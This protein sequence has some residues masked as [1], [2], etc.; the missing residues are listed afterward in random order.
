MRF[1]AAASIVAVLFSL[2]S[3]S[4]SQSARTVALNAEASR[5]ASSQLFQTQTKPSELAVQG[6][7]NRVTPKGKRF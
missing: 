2:V 5:V 7:K 6:P 4:L 3:M 1:T